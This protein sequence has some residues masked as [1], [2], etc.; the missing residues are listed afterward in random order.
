MVL[1]QPFFWWCILSFFLGGGQSARTFWLKMFFRNL[2]LKTQ[3]GCITVTQKPTRIGQW[4]CNH[5]RA[6]EAG[7]RGTLVV[8]GW[9]LEERTTFALMNSS[10]LVFCCFMLHIYIN[11]FHQKI[12]SQFCPLTQK[13]YFFFSFPTAGKSNKLLQGQSAGE[14]SPVVSFHQATSA[15]GPGAGA[16]GP[17]ELGIRNFQ[18]L[19]L[20][21][22]LKL[23]RLPTKKGES[24]RKTGR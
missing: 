7:N 4:P 9:V 23:H 6:E 22:S 13:I 2:T 19:N 21:E 3:T 16:V 18:G 14:A 10:I 1:A 5:S 17:E 15:Q 8:L 12:P 11:A 24:P 20:W